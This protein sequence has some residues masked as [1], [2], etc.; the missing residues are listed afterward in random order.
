MFRISTTTTNN[1]LI[2]LL[3]WKLFQRPLPGQPTRL[4]TAGSDT[5]VVIWGVKQEQ[6]DKVELNCLCDLTRYIFMANL[7]SVT[8]EG[9]GQRKNPKN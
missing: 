9:R 7:P 6:E 4:A 5:H 8:L 2:F 1:K 3:K